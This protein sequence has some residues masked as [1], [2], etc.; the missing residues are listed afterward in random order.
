MDGTEAGPHR[1]PQPLSALRYRAASIAA[2]CVGIIEGM[3]IARL[4]ARALAARPDNPSVAFL[5]WVTDPLIT[6]LAGLQPDLPT[7]G[8][9]VELVT[10]GLALL[11]PFLAWGIWIALRRRATEPA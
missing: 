9:A 7:Y 11:A 4:A 2:W 5:Y 1:L 6:P 8:A 10:L 3:L